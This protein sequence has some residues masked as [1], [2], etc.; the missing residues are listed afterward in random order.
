MDRRDILKMAIGFTPLAIAGKQFKQITPE[1][2]KSLPAGTTFYLANPH[3]VDIVELCSK[4]IL[5]GQVIEVKCRKGM[6]ISD[7]FQA[8][9]I[10]YEDHAAEVE[11]TADWLRQH[12]Q[13]E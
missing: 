8:H 6:G 1:E 10:D 7:E 12:G 4:A 13:P 9:R 3:A 11:T 2:V 5:P